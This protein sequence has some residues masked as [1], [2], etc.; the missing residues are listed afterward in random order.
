MSDK[1]VLEITILIEVDTKLD[2]TAEV[3]KQV[4]KNAIHSTDWCSYYKV[5]DGVICTK[6][7]TRNIK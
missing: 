5:L 7:I 2:L 4:L 3:K 6:E 1:K